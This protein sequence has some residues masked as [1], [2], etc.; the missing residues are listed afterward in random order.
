MDTFI[1][2]LAALRRSEVNHEKIMQ[3]LKDQAQ[4]MKEPKVE[5]K[6]EK[7]SNRAFANQGV[8]G[9]DL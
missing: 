5:S 3:R 4:A 1:Y 7:S 2:G 8:R 9:W 6:N